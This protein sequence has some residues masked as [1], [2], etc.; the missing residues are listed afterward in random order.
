[1]VAIDATSSTMV[2]TPRAPPPRY[3][4]QITL[5]K[6]IYSDNLR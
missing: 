4:P 2:P 3:P 5:F 6:C 1:V